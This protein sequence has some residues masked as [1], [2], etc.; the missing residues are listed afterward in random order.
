[1]RRYTLRRTVH[2]WFILV[3][4][5]APLRLSSKLKVTPSLSTSGK[6]M[7]MKRE[8]LA[9]KVRAAVKEH[10]NLLMTRPR[11]WREVVDSGVHCANPEWELFLRFWNE[12]RETAM[13][14]KVV[15]MTFKAGV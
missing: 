6:E 13:K 12:A 5:S 7:E 2:D 11:A 14:G 9:E 10:T 15:K 4:V 8:E 1:M 3:K